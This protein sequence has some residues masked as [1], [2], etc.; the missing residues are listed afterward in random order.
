MKQQDF[1]VDLQRNISVLLD[2]VDI[3]THLS[4]LLKKENTE[5]EVVDSKMYRRQ[6]KV[7]SIINI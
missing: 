4:G 2:T 6:V 5:D 3:G 7:W 1:Y